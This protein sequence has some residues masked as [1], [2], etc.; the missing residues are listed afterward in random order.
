MPDQNKPL[1]KPSTLVPEDGQHLASHRAYLSNPVRVNPNQI[2]VGD[3]IKF[4]YSGEERTVFV[5]NPEWH[6]FLHG[7]SMKAIDRRTLMV[8]IVAKADMYKTPADFYTRVIKQEP[9]QKTDSYRTYEIRKMGNIRK[10][11]YQ[12]D[13]R[14][15]EEAGTG[16]LHDTTVESFEVEE[17]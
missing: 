10:L 13:E 16:E 9:I 7:L 17:L 5:L 1:T 12:V 14:G 6:L 2:N 11:T 15:R 4:M 3:V 8:E